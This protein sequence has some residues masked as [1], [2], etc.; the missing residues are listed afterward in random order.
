MGYI[1]EKGYFHLKGSIMSEAFEIVRAG[2]DFSAA[3]WYF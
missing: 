1:E 2:I 3:T